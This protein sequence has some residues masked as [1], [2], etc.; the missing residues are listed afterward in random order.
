[1]ERFAKI[2][3]DQMLLTVFTKSSILDVLLTFG[4][5]FDDQGVFS[6]IID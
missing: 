5:V 3:N 4:E 6:N 2:V 1:M